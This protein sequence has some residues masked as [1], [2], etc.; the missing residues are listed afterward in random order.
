MGQGKQIYCSLFKFCPIIFV[1]LGQVAQCGSRH[2]PTAEKKT[3]TTSPKQ[4]WQRA[5]SLPLCKHKS[6]SI[7]HLSVHIRIKQAKTSRSSSISGIKARFSPSTTRTT[8][9]N[10]SERALALAG[11]MSTTGHCRNLSHHF[12]RV[13]YFQCDTS[14]SES[15]W[16][17]K[18]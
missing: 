18:K 14:Y 12:Q 5:R 13:F 9:G 15:E 6:Y 10:L 7:Q 17:Q 8:D 1:D 3:E 16:P 4:F 11:F 2:V